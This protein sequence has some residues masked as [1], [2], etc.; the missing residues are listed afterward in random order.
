MRW[1]PVQQQEGAVVV[2]V[3]AAME[4]EIA[5]LDDAEQ[6]EFLKDLGLSEPG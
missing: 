5:Q 4:A 2:A 1:R 6:G 3:C